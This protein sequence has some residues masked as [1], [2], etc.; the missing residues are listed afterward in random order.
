MAKRKKNRDVRDFL[1][2]KHVYQ[3]EVAERLGVHET[4]VIR[5]LREELPEERKQA[6]I[7]A[8]IAIAAER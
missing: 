1:K 7:A 3:W 4:T 8:A 5:W 6:M 2:Q